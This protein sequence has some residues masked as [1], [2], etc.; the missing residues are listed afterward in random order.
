[1]QGLGKNVKTPV[2]VRQVAVKDQGGD[3]DVFGVAWN[4]NPA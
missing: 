2:V 3:H 1:M 4:P